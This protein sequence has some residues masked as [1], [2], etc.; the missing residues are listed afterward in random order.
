MEGKIKL[1]CIFLS[2]VLNYLFG[3]FDKWLTA[4]LII[5]GIDIA[6]GIVKAAILG[7]YSSTKFRV[8]TLKKSAYLLCIL[9]AVQMDIVLGEGGLVRGACIGAFMFNEVSSMIEN[10][11]QMG[12][13]VPEF[14]INSLEVLKNK[15]NKNEEV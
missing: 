7:E 14:M 10:F 8:G 2:G 3:G 9:T 15:R 1:I 6:T 11:G 4:F 13:P 12:A 5:M